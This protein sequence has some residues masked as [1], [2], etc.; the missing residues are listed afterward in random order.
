MKAYLIWFDI[1]FKP[2]H[3][4][5]YL[6]NL[7]LTRDKDFDSKYES[8]S[9][10]NDFAVKIRYPDHIIMPSEKELQ[11]AIELAQHVKELVDSKVC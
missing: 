4:L 6:L 5:R 10:L 1:E 11:A 8:I 2:V 3:D 9:A 7:V